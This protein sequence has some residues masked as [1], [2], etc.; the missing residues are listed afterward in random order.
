ME[1]ETDFGAFTD[2]NHAADEIMAAMHGLLGLEY[3]LV[4]RITG[5]DWVVLRTFGPG[6]YTIGQAI[7][8]SSTIC[9]HMIAGRGPH[10]VT[11][12]ANHE[13]YAAA[14]IRSVHPVSSYAGAPLIVDG[15]VYGVLC[16]LDPATRKA[17]IEAHARL[18]V[19]SAR[20]LST[21]LTH[22]LQA[23]ELLRR[24]ERA[25]SEA[26]VDELTGFF[27]RRGW[28]RLIDREARRAERYG[29]QATIFMMDIDGLKETNDAEGH[30]AGDIL[31]KRVASAIRSA[32]RDNDIAARLG[33]DEF[34]VLAIESSAL[35]AQVLND[36]FDAAFDAAGVRVS[37]GRAHC[38]RAGGIR[39]ALNAA[40]EMMYLLKDHR[41]ARRRP[42]VASP[43]ESAST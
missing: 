27:N 39:N 7:D 37:I 20:T 25:E 5:D 38:N 4:T 28:D 34:G 42:A 17:D 15:R 35:D 1:V 24:A 8:Y 21:I 23:D 26:L 6:P 16:A 29:N 40:D 30:A 36:R 12:V 19:T 33:G 9:S 31:I 41:R 10:I 32:M 13:H 2:F 22:Q 18:V 14:L 43:T 3:W 11:D